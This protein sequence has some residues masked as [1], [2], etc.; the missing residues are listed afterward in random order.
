M[1]PSSEH[2]VYYYEA[3]RVSAAG[4]MTASTNVKEWST[5]IVSWIVILVVGS[6]WIMLDLVQK[7]VRSSWLKLGSLSFF[8]PHFASFGCAKARNLSF[9]TWWGPAGSS[10]PVPVPAGAT[11]WP[12]L[13]TVDPRLYTDCTQTIHRP[14][15]V[16]LLPDVLD[17]ELWYTMIMRII[18]PFAEVNQVMRPDFE[19]FSVFECLRQLPLTRTQFGWLIG[20]NKTVFKLF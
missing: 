15:A 1:T 7:P 17:V 6:C 4:V 3:L 13:T 14:A 2:F 19:H 11:G 16:F 9:E 20:K 5:C 10:P 18:L 12:W 8:F